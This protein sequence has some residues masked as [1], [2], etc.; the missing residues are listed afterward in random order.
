MRSVKDIVKTLLQFYSYDFITKR[1]LNLLLY[2]AQGLHL[3]KTGRPLFKE[4]MKSLPSGP[5]V[6]LWNFRFGLL[7][8]IFNGNSCKYV[9]MVNLNE[10]ELHTL[11]MVAQVLGSRQERTLLH[12]LYADRNPWTLT[13]FGHR[14]SKK[15]MESYF[16]SHPVNYSSMFDLETLERELVD[17]DE[18]MQECMDDVNEL[19]ES[20]A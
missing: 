2:F 5:T 11:T 20:L 15:L 18:E 14:I 9:N 4:E 6:Y 17:H 12:L 10:E 19:M 7:G 13:P 16:L 1:K 8:G 3:A